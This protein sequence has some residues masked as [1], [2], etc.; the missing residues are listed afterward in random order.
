MYCVILVVLAG[1]DWRVLHPFKKYLNFLRHFKVKRV[2]KSVSKTSPFAILLFWQLWIHASELV[3]RFKSPRYIA[4]Q[5]YTY[6]FESTQSFLSCQISD[7]YDWRI[8]YG[9]VSFRVSI[10]AYFNWFL[11]FS[12]IFAFFVAFNFVLTCTYIYVY[13]IHHYIVKER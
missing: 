1:Q 8:N 7:T 2:N 5:C 9:T 6:T 12:E 3:W 4:I 11:S 10:F 13:I